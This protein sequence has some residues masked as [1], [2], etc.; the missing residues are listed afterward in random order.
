MIIRKTILTERLILKPTIEEDAEFIFELLNTPK[1]LKFIGDR[2][3]NSSIDAAEYIKTRMLPQLERLGYG[4]YTVVRTSDNVKIG[5]CGLFDREGLEGIDIGFAFLPGYEGQGYG[6]ESANKLKEV[7]FEE[8]GIKEMNAITS[9]ENIN[10]QKLLEKL[11]LKLKGTTILPN[12]KE[13]LLL[14]GIKNE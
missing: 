5:T 1:W 9:K 13:E 4:N 2:N 7:A 12:E 8:F 3:V 11:G 10:C 14:Y 6:F